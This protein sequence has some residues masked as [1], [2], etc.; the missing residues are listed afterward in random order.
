MLPGDGLV[1]LLDRPAPRERGT[2]G[3]AAASIGC[4]YSC[5]RAR[6]C[7]C[8]RWCRARR[9]LP[10]GPLSLAVYPGADCH[11]SLY[12]DD[13]VSFAYARGNY[14]RQAFSCQQTTAELVVNVAVR[15]GSY[16]PWWS[17]FTLELHGMQ[18]DE[19]AELK[20]RRLATRFDKT[21]GTLLIE[22]SDSASDTSV[23]IRAGH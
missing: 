14:L 2:Q 11:G 15:Q 18:G 7:R 12:L 13:G 21:S 3:N 17:Q 9:K 8:S 10:H 22:L 20:G 4:R 19:I 5:G 1:R 23:K 16:R 6:S